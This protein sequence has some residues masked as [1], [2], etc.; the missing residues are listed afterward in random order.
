MHLR[1]LLCKVKLYG[2]NGWA[3]LT[4]RVIKVLGLS[5]N[6]RRM[7]GSENP[8]KSL[9][10]SRKESVRQDAGL[11][12]QKTTYFRTLKL[13]ATTWL[14]SSPLPSRSPRI[15]EP[16]RKD[17]LVRISGILKGGRSHAPP[18]GPDQI[19][20]GEL[21]SGGFGALQAPATNCIDCLR[22]WRSVCV[23]EPLLTQFLRCSKT[24]HQ[25]CIRMTEGAD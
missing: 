10:A 23:T 3:T 6:F 25:S 20:R 5:V 12:V 16:L 18:R 9:T 24:V 11:W 17:L 8:G 21:G 7:S 14:P 2:A 22:D 4:Y 13:A 15:S 19:G 1:P